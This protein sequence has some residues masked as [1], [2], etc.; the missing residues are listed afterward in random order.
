MDV[1]TD[2]ELDGLVEAS[3]LILKY[4]RAVDR[5]SA[6]EILNARLEMAARR[7]PA[8]IPRYEA[9]KTPAPRTTNTQP[10]AEKSWFEKAINSSAGKQVQRSVVRTLF[11]V[12]Q[13]MFK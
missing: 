4:N 2:A 10:K 9:P 6:Y 13:K 8:P 7:E 11:G 12:I 3:T 5:E 1:L